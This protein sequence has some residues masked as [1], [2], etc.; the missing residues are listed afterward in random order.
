MSQLTAHSETGKIKSLILKSAKSAFQSPEKIEDEWLALRFLSA[1][2]YSIAETEYL[3]FQSL[4]QKQDIVL[5]FLPED[6]ESTLDSIYCRDA[7]I[8]TD[9]GLILCNMGKEARAAEPAAIGELARQV[10]IPIL[11]IIRKP[12]TLEGGDVA[13]INRNTLAVGYSYRTN[14]S[15]IRQLAALL[16]P[17]GVSIIQVD[18]PH[19]QGK[20][21]VFHLMS[22]FSPVDHELAVVYSPLMPIA[23][24][25]LLLEKSFTLI[26]VPDSEFDSMGCNVLALAPGLCLMLEG[27]PK[28]RQA[29]ED[30]GCKVITYRGEEI[31]MKGGGGPTC[32]TRPL[33]RDIS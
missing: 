9:A 30:H 1:P 32:L 33:Y 12:G 4:L 24:R 15:G 10:E 11:G 25:K 17:L 16:K 26:E 14:L 28:T 7:A 5:S 6:N 21:D 19:Y 29:L 2:V 3:E 23:F 8:M 22:V 13:W 18:L 31:S 27:N 20:E